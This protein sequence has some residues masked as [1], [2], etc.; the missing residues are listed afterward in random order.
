MKWL[1]LLLAR[2]HARKAATAQDGADEHRKAARW[3]LRKAGGG[4]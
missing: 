3:F 4:E 1:W 2:Y